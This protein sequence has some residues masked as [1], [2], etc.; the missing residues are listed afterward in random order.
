MRW[1]DKQEIDHTTK[2]NEVNIP[3][4]H[5]TTTGGAGSEE[6]FNKAFDDLD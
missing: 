2:G 4:T 6:D 3:I 1:T 5:W